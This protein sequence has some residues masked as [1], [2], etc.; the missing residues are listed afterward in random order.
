M[1]LANGDGFGFLMST[2]VGMIA[3]L[4]NKGKSF[5]NWHINATY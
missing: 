5:A 3:T 1:K 2:K 4:L